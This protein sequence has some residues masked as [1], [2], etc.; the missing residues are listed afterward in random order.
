MALTIIADPKAWIK[1]YFSAAS[2]VYILVLDVIRGRN[3][4]KFSSRPIQAVNHEV[5]D[6]AIMTPRVSVLKKVIFLRVIVTIK[7]RS[8]LHR[9]P[10]SI[11]L[12]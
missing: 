6:I 3:D 1:K 2:E 10:D 8:K 7:K 4:N 12:S 5:E 11:N 9:W